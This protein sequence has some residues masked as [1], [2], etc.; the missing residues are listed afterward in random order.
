MSWGSRYCPEM[1]AGAVLSP[2]SANPG[3]TLAPPVSPEMP[4][5]PAILL[6]VQPQRNAVISLSSPFHLPKPACPCSSP[7]HH[8]HRI[9]LATGS[10]ARIT[11]PESPFLL[12]FEKQKYPATT[13]CLPSPVVRTEA[14]QERNA[15]TAPT[16]IEPR[17]YWTEADFSPI[18]PSNM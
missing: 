15:D 1:Q 17:A 18:M 10:T 2:S 11:G 12:S 13:P 6:S 9:T 16:L 4:L 5:L 8:L 14:H 3:K 7:P